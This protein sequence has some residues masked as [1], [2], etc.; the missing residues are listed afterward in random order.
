MKVKTLPA[1]LVLIILIMVSQKNVAG[2][3][4]SGTTITKFNLKPTLENMGFETKDLG[5]DSYQITVNQ[6]TIVPMSV[7]LSKDE[8]RIWLITFFGDKVL[9]NLSSDKL[10]KLLQSNWSTG[11]S[12]FV[13]NGN[14]LEMLHP[15]ENRNV[16][17]VLLRKEIESQ[18]RSVANTE[19]LWADKDK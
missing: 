6:G 9:A 12:F 15:V 7:S 18:A 5:A 19:S 10:I 17:P 3:S 11:V 13:L 16:T 1:A 8:S 4:S 14:K 2:Q